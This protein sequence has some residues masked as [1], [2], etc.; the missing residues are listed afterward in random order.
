[1]ELESSSNDRYEPS[2]HNLSQKLPN[3]VKVNNSE[4]LKDFIV[5]FLEENNPTDDSTSTPINL[6]R[7]KELNDWAINKKEKETSNVQ[8][9][10]DGE[11]LSLV[12]SKALSKLDQIRAKLSSF[13]Q[14]SQNDTSMQKSFGP[15][16]KQQQNPGNNSKE[17]NEENV[18]KSYM[19]MGG[20][21]DLQTQEES[22]IVEVYVNGNLQN[23]ANF[24]TPEVD[25]QTSD[26]YSGMN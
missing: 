7:A 26:F 10:S 12:E 15:E 18:D 19:E 2:N 25:A 8:T 23:V 9:N 6:D 13:L 3:V 14:A 4:Q 24:E 11:E 17:I 1:M 5:N 20:D 16:E 22:Q 21:E